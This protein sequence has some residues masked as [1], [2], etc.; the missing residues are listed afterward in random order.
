MPFLGPVSWL[1]HQKWDS[2]SKLPSIPA[3]TPILMLSGSKD[4][5]VPPVQMEALWKLWE[6]H[7]GKGKILVF[8]K[9]QHSEWFFVFGY[10]LVVI[11]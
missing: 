10:C 3:T 4:E 7:K 5:V 9:G 6:E 11:D 8:E 2:A 1:C